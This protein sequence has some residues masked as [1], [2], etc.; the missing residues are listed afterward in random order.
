MHRGAWG[1][2]INDEELALMHG[3][4]GGALVVC[5]CGLVDGVTVICVMERHRADRGLTSRAPGHTSIRLTDLY[6]R[7]LSAV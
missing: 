1:S 6:S 5:V 2:N 3:R 7:S 4:S